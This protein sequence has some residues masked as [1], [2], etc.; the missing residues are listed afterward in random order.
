MFPIEQVDQP[1]FRCEFD[2]LYGG[3]D[4]KDSVLKFWGHSRPLPVFFRT[5][6]DQRNRVGVGFFRV[7]RLRNCVRDPVSVKDYHLVWVS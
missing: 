5:T 6:R 7:E 2:E 4:F 1:R 3:Y